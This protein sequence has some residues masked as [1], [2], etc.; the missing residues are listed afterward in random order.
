MAKSTKKTPAPAQSKKVPAK[1]PRTV[2]SI[3]PFH[4]ELPLAERRAA[5]EA[6]RTKLPREA[7]GEWSRRSDFP[8]WACGAILARAHARTTDIA[9]IA[10]YCG[11]SS[12]LDDAL[13]KWAEAY[14][15]QTVLDHAALVQAV[16]NDRAVQNMMGK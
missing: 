5:G 7:H 16:S 6:L 14:G 12:V 10:G 2:E 3:I 8:V 15:D 11:N 13:A 9:L 4:G 1:A